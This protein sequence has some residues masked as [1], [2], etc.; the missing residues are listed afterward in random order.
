M[1]PLFMPPLYGKLLFPKFCDATWVKG[2][3]GSL[4]LKL[5]VICKEENWIVWMLVERPVM[6][7][8]KSIDLNEVIRE[9]TESANKVMWKV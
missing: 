5:K 3:S 9:N 8:L 1:V 4:N 7:S 6:R 2:K